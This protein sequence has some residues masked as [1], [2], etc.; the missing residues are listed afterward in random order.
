MISA[1]HAGFLL[2]QVVILLVI[3]AL[4]WRRMVRFRA[5][6]EVTVFRAYMTD[7]VREVAVR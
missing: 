2:L 1:R 6:S 4:S 5:L 3:G 7:S